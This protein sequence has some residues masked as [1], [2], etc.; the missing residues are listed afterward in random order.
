MGTYCPFAL[1]TG[2]TIDQTI[3][4]G[5]I[6]MG[7][8][9]TLDFSSNP[10]GVKW[11]M[12]PDQ[13]AGY[14]IACPDL[15]YQQPTPVGINAGVGFWIS[16]ELTDESFISVANEVAK[17]HGASTFNSMYEAISWL[18][19][20]G[21]PTT[22]P[23]GDS[24]CSEYQAVYD[25]M[26]NKPT[27]LDLYVQNWLAK[28]LVSAN[29]W[30]VLD[31]IRFYGSHTNSGSEACLDWKWPTGGPSLMD[32][33]KGTFDSGKEGWT[34][35]GNN[36]VT[37]SG[38]VLIVTYVDNTNGAYGYIKDSATDPVLGKAYKARA[39]CKKSAGGAA[40]FQEVY[41]STS[42]EITTTDFAWYEIAFVCNNLNAGLRLSIGTG[43][44]VYCDTW[45]IQEWTG[46]S[47]INS[48]V[49]TARQGFQFNGTTNY[50]KQNWVPSVSG[51]NFIQDSASQI[52]Y[53]RT[54]IAGN[55][56]HGVAYN[57]NNKNAHFIPRDSTNLSNIRFNTNLSESGSNSNGSGM[58]IV[59]RPAPGVHLLY[60]NKI[61][62]IN[63]TAASVGVPTVPPY[64]GASRGDTTPG[65]YRADQV[66]FEAW[67]G[68]LDQDQV[69]DLT[70]IVN[71]AATLLGVNVF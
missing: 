27:G 15:N 43:T 24:I 45:D 12:G 25:V 48:P 7:T 55:T 57:T 19:L 69:N 41:S 31:I 52:Y 53:I 34:K 5:D 14:V 33:G 29:L 36:T 67:G 6:A 46:A 21:F 4:F 58:F 50:L 47:A 65:Y 56:I 42:I 9:E 68:G 60:K 61:I 62:K 37:A 38:G 64:T 66:F 35:Y 18:A 71:G 22:Y 63:G 2:N 40:Y 13:D 49:Y 16:A 10:G 59:T 44:T 20:S 51:V 70:D 11:W 3:Q 26:P 1:N 39:Y 54:N 28:N 17:C 30:N 8:N 23:I 32:P